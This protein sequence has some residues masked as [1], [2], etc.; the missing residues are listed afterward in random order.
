MHMS[1]KNTQKKPREF[2]T[3]YTMLTSSR[4]AKNIELLYKFAQR[5]TS[6]NE[7]KKTRK[8]EKTRL[9][10]TNKSSGHLEICSQ[11][12]V[13]TFPINRIAVRN[14]RPDN[15]RYNSRSNNLL[16]G[17]EKLHREE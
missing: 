5:E 7:K 12:L 15:I 4:I 6:V 3:Q 2:T 14:R 1:I 16:S 11:V 8:G 13:E 10:R 9:I 17:A